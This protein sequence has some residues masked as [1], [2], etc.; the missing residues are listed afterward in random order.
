MYDFG[1]KETHVSYLPAAHALELILQVVVSL[2]HS[3]GYILYVYTSTVF[4]N[5]CTY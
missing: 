1:A 2:I 5:T 3:N 4:Q